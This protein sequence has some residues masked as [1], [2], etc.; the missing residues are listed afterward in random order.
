MDRWDRTFSLLERPTGRT[1]FVLL[2]ASIV[3]RSQI[4]LEPEAA[5][6]TSMR[7]GAAHMA[8]RQA[9]GDAPPEPRRSGPPQSQRQLAPEPDGSIWPS[10]EYVMSGCI[11]ARK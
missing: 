2:G 1:L 11:A 5:R 8:G 7:R 3:E 9:G 10:D 4:G 6:W